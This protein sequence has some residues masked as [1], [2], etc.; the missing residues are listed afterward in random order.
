M[1]KEGPACGFSGQIAIKCTRN[2]RAPA[3]FA[4]T[5]DPDH[6]DGPVKRNRHHIT[7]SHLVTGGRHAL[8]VKADKSCRCKRGGIGPCPH[9]S[10]MPQPFVDAL[11]FQ[12]LGT[13]AQDGS[14]LVCSSC[15]LSAASLAN[16]EFGSGC[17]SR[18]PEPLPKGFA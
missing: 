16:G 12:F 5:F 3:P 1:V 8:A 11:T 17:L 2:G 9:H 10:R 6:P 15:C 7:N 4:K 13:R 14:L 18:P